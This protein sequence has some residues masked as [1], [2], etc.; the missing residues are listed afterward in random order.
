MRPRRF[1]AARPAGSLLLAR[2]GSPW[3][4]AS[5]S[6]RLVRASWRPLWS[7]LSD[8]GIGVG[9]VRWP[10]TYPAQPVQGFVLSDRFHDLIGSLLELD[11]RAAYPANALPVA[12]N[13]FLEHA[14]LPESLAGRETAT[15]GTSAPEGSAELRDRFYSR[16]MR[17][18]GAAWPVQFSACEF[19]GLD[20][21]GHYHPRYTQPRES[22]D[23]SDD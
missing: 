10:L 16:A 23:V 13:A 7:I 2:P 15:S 3:V 1:A 18:L 22:G 9:V 5:R 20:T 14:D 19:Q 21:V 17:D 8:A 11:E 6:Q 4:P 12:R